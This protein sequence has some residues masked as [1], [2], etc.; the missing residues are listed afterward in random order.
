MIKNIKYKFEGMM[1]ILP[2][3][4]TEDGDIDQISERRLV[5]Y[6]LQNSARAIG[7]LAGASEINKLSESD[8]NTLIEVL[9]DEVNGRVPVFIGVTAPSKR[10]AVRYALQA[11][12]LGADL[13]MAALPYANIPTEKE[14]YDYYKAISEAVS[15]PIIIQ[16][17]CVGRTI[18]S[19]EFMWELYSDFS[20][21]CYIKAEDLDF[22]SKTAK[23]M[24]FSKDGS[25][26]IGGFGGRY[27]IHMLRMGV[28]AFMTGTEALD[29][30]N[31]VVSLY[32]NG[33]I[34]KSI[35]SYYNCLLPY[36]GIFEQY[37]EELPKKMLKWRGIISSDK[38]IS[39]CSSR[40]LITESELEEFRWVLNKIGFFEYN[41]ESKCRIS[42]SSQINLAD[43][44]LKA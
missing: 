44:V 20:N 37:Y 8:R 39:P 17:V 26:I 14:A 2:T 12:K 33:E 35:E 16:D 42:G 41:L 11:Q 38:L 9:I 31:K 5:S 1:P 25:E 23:L 43:T 3:A 19:A 32:L 36:L 24:E 27:M 10:V 40:P 21:I 28:K 30:H 15:L 6:C 4:I 7:H 22:L 13:L 29:I 18:L 34:K